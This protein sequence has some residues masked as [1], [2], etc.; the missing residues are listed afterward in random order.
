METKKRNESHPSWQC[1]EILIT[2]YSWKCRYKTLRKIPSVYWVLDIG[3]SL[4]LSLFC[5]FRKLVRKNPYS[6]WW[7]EAESNCRPLV[8]QTM[9]NL[10]T[11]HNCNL[12]VVN[13]RSFV[14]GFKSVW[15]VNNKQF[16]CECVTILWQILDHI[17]QK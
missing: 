4:F 1:Y 8:F 7:P 3:S 15:A 16:F 5:F 2:I 12:F 13:Y 6:Y 10:V 11:F 14:R 17:Q 9:D